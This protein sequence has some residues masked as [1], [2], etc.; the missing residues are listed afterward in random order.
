MKTLITIIIALFTQ[1]TFASEWKHMNQQNDIYNIRLSYTYSYLPATYG[2]EGGAIA[3]LF[4]VDLYSYRA[5]KS[6]RVEIFEIQRDGRLYRVAQFDLTED[7]GSHSYGKK[8]TGRTYADQIWK[9][10]EYLYR[11]YVDGR[12]IEGRFKI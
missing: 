1:I 8:P 5:F 9:K 2:S 10:K 11:I 7:H 4:Y 3:G 12:I 6:D